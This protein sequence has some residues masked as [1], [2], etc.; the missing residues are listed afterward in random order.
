MS[1]QVWGVECPLT[2]CVCL[3]SPGVSIQWQTTTY[4]VSEDSGTVQLVLIKADATVSNVSVKIATIASS[5]IGKSVEECQTGLMVCMMYH[6]LFS[7]P[8]DYDAINSS[9]IIFSPAQTSATVTVTIVDDDVLEDVEQ[10]IVEVVATG[11]QE[12]VDVG[13]VVNITIFND[14][15]EKTYISNPSNIL[16]YLPLSPCPC[17]IL[18]CLYM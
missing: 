12:R 8:E 2:Q 13:D 15:C 6:I 9:T 10:F 7:A 16:L 14:D 3:I 18:V 1:V 4:T 11:G 5:A 17:Y